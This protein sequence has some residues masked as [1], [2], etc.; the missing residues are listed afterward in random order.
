MTPWQTDLPDSDTTVLARIEDDEWPLSLA[1]HDGEC[2][3]H[4]AAAER[5]VQPV[6]GWMHPHS[7]IDVLDKLSVFLQSCEGEALKLVIPAFAPIP[8]SITQ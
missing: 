1:F 6:I 3:R 2:W 4:A 8:S 7:A 5:I